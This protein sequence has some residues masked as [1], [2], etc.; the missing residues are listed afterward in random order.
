MYII[1]LN[2]KVS[3]SK[4]NKNKWAKKYQINKGYLVFFH[5]FSMF[6]CSYQQHSVPM[7]SCLS[8]RPSYTSSKINSNLLLENLFSGTQCFLNLGQWNGGGKRGSNPILIAFST[9]L[10][11]TLAQTGVHVVISGFTLTSMSHG[12]KFS[13][14]IKSKPKISKMFSFRSVSSLRKV[15]CI[16][17]VAIAFICGYMSSIKLGF[18]IWY[19]PSR[20]FCNFQ[21]VILFPSSYLP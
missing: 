3:N 20:N 6:L 9:M 12:L 7:Q 16:V 17:S 11:I 2:S 21:N 19:S 18:L 14:I 4:N 5:C 1:S 10:G 8:S 13:S 15:A